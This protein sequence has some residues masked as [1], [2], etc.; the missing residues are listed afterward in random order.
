MLYLKTTSGEILKGSTFSCF[1]FVYNTEILYLYV[2]DIL[3]ISLHRVIREDK[4]V[5]DLSVSG[6]SAFRPWLLHVCV[7]CVVNDGPGTRRVSV[8]VPIIGF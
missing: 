7:F 1:T 6:V 2:F 5:R 8:W 4:V 3:Y